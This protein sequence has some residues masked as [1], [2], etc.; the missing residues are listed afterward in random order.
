MSH[1]IF[2]LRCSSSASFG[3]WDGTKQL[4]F[5]LNARK[6]THEPQNG[7]GIELG[8]RVWESIL[9]FGSREDGA[10]RAPSIFDHGQNLTL[11]LVH[12][13]I[14][15]SICD[16]WKKIKSKVRNEKNDERSLFVKQPQGDLI[17][18]PETKAK[19]V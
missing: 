9:L 15:R 12:Y 11:L 7:M 1:I 18:K 10:Q 19:R 16:R 4:G 8:G 17:P 5:R 6:R 14:V 2:L 13:F 3:I